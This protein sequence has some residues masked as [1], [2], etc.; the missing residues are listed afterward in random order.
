MQAAVTQHQQNVVTCAANRKA[1]IAK[2]RA[3]RK[4]RTFEKKVRYASRQKLAE[5]RPRVRGQFVKAN[6]Y[7][8]HAAA[9]EKKPQSAEE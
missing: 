3:K 5:A 4:S 1:A 2:F 7:A 8:A 6:V 9:E